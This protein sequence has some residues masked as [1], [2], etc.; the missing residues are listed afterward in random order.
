MPLKPL[1]AMRTQL[2]NAYFILLVPPPI[3]L[4]KWRVLTPKFVSWYF[5]RHIALMQWAYSSNNR[6]YTRQDTPYVSTSHVKDCEANIWC[7]SLRRLRVPDRCNR[8]CR[9][10]ELGAG[11]ER[12]HLQASL[13]RAIECIL[14]QENMR[15]ERRRCVGDHGLRLEEWPRIRTCC[16]AAWLLSEEEWYAKSQIICSLMTTRYRSIMTRCISVQSL[17]NL[18]EVIPTHVLV[19][20]LGTLCERP[21]LHPW[22]KKLPRGTKT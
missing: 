17:Y 18:Q 19:F 12:R 21:G 5:L 2:H 7:T 15:I 22:G 6:W 16:A 11:L 13:R 20:D 1:N 8:S 4:G 10:H 14:K 3:W 9:L